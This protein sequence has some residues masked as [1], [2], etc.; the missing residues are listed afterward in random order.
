[1]RV[2][3]GERFDYGVDLGGFILKDR[4]WFFGAY[5]RVTRPGPTCPGRVVDA[6]PDATTVPV[7]RDGQPLLGKAHLECASIDV[8]VGTV[9]A[10][11]STTPER[12]EPTRARDSA[13][14]M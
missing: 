3:D 7:R 5:N 4:L 8:V 9:F 11:P 6:R 14:S 13:P 1:M 12:R 10:D 2:A